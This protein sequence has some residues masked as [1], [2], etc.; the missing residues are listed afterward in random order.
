MEQFNT[1]KINEDSYWVTGLSKIKLFNPLLV[2][3]VTKINGN[4][5]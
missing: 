4:I 1:Y 5:Y 2:G 3:E